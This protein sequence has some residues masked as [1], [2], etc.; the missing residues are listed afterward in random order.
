MVDFVT[1]VMSPPAPPPPPPQ[2]S[3]VL[4]PPPPSPGPETKL[5]SE[6]S[7]H[8]SNVVALDNDHLPVRP[9]VA[10]LLVGVREF[11]YFCQ[12]VRR[13]FVVIGWMCACAQVC[14][15]VE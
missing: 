6:Q 7:C 10:I 5:T 1:P 11:V 2:P 14:G 15:Y 4:S 13:L 12:C 9:H 8:I 3:R